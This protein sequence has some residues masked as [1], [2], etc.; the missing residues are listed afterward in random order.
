MAFWIMTLCCL[1]VPMGMESVPETLYCLNHLTRLEAREDFI[2]PKYFG[3]LLTYRPKQ[4]EILDLQIQ[5]FNHFNMTTLRT[6]EFY[7]I[8]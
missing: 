6:I 1:V 7:N 4:K 3:R 8:L 2:T 5:T